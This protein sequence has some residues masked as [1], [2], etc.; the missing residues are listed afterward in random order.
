MSCP[1]KIHSTEKEL[2]WT[3]KPRKTKGHAEQLAEIR[4]DADRPAGTYHTNILWWTC[5]CPAYLTSRFLTCKHIVCQVNDHLNDKPLTNLEFFAKLRCQHSPPFFQ[6]ESIHFT[7][8]AP[9]VVIRIPHT[10]LHT[11]AN[12]DLHASRVAGNVEDPTKDITG[13][14]RAGYY[15]K[16]YQ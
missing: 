5:S 3:Y 4:A 8:P 15:N 1:D 2:E 11:L 12:V 7:P 6:I 16:S 13:K 9:E 10:V 14:F